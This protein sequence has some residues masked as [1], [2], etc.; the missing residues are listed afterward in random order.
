MG[1]AQQCA[2]GL[3]RVLKFAFSPKG[4]RITRPQGGKPPGYAE[5]EIVPGGRQVG[6][7]A[8]IDAEWRKPRG[9]SSVASWAA[10]ADATATRAKRADSDAVREE[11]GPIVRSSSFRTVWA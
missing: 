3:E 11:I 6:A 10:A 7:Q 2:N 1:P 9:E 5:V 4:E 8:L